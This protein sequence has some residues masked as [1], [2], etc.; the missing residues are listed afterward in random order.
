[1]TPPLSADLALGAAI[2]ELPLAALSVPRGREG[3]AYSQLRAA[4]PGSLLEY[5]STLR[6]LL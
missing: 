5:R 2:P 3:E 1:M 4:Q 6:V